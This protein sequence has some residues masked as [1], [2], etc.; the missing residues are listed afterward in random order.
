MKIIDHRSVAVDFDEVKIGQEF[1]H[2]GRIYW[3]CARDAGYTPG[4]CG[5]T[6]FKA[7]A[8]VEP[9]EVEIHIKGK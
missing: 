9:V 1:M 3:K 5:F 6:Y 4:D 2:I 8:R 7:G